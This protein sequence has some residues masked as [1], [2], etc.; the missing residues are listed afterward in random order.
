M[1]IAFDLD[2]V[3]YP[4]HRVV[5]DLYF[6][7]RH[8]DLT[9]DMFWGNVW[10]SVP[11]DNWKPFLNQPDS[12]MQP[13]R[14]DVV[15]MMHKI[16]QKRFVFY[17]TQRNPTLAKTTQRWLVKNG[18]PNPGDV[19]FSTSKLEVCRKLEIDLHVD[20]RIDV[21]NELADNGI[22]VLGVKQPGN[23]DK[24]H[25]FPHVDNILSLEREI[26]RIETAQ[27]GHR[28]RNGN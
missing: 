4:G 21:M 15:Q 17:I 7:K 3:L 5:W 20:D 1:K 28:R 18:F 8:P 19:Y 10:K 16:S 24:I 14:A 27:N 12:Y 6:S 9:Y 26:A 11:K 23:K 25:D 22:R 2:G 13:A